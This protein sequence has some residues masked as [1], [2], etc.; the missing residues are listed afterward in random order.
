MLQLM[1]WCSLNFVARSAFIFVP[2]SWHFFGLTHLTLQVLPRLLPRYYFYHLLHHNLYVL[3][4]HQIRKIY[5]IF[6]YILHCFTRRQWILKKKPRETEPV[7][8]Y[9][10][11]I[12]CSLPSREESEIKFY[13]SVQ[14]EASCQLGLWSQRRRANSFQRW[15]TLEGFALWASFWVT[16]GWSTLQPE[17]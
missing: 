3:I 10:I 9:S 4:L 13:V 8:S 12:C 5:C 6:K 17:A 1:F 11:C 7:L 14:D 16:T 2:I 15:M